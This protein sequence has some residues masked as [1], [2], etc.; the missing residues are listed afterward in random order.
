[1]IH[2][3]MQWPEAS[4]VFNAPRTLV[5]TTAPYSDT[6]RGA[7]VLHVMTPLDLI[8]HLES[9]DNGLVTVILMDRFA[10]DDVL[11]AF[12]R[13]HYPRI[14]VRIESPVAELFDVSDF[15]VA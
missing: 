9:P 13:E 12:L 7:D 11:Y 4:G 6:P 3:P 14:D 5:M 8:R 10:S 15:L 2:K 1:M